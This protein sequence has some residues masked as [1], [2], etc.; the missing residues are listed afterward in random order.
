M[1][2]YQARTRAD[3]VELPR[4]SRGRP[5]PS[6]DAT[7]RAS[8]ASWCALILEIKSSSDLASTPTSWRQP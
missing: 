4:R 8:V 2:A 1:T 3:V 6:A 5:S 7:Y